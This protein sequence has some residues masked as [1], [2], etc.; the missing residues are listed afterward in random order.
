MKY[1]KFLFL[2]LTVLTY[3]LYA[4]PNWSYQSHIEQGGSG[5]N[6]EGKQGAPGNPGSGGKGASGSGGAGGPGSR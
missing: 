6:K 2:P 1:A 3:Q 4:V 5:G